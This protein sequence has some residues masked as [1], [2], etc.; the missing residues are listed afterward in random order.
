MFWSDF[1]LSEFCLTW[2]D[3][4]FSFRFL[5]YFDLCPSSTYEYGLVLSGLV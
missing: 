3:S 5:V 2:F 4:L 1:L